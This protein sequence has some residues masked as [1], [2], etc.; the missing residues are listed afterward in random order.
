MTQEMVITLARDAIELTLLLSL[1]FLVVGLV[2]GLIISVFQAATQIQEMSLTFVPKAITMLLAG[3]LLLPFLMN[4][5]L[6]F[7]RHLFA[8]IPKY[9]K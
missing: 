7:T 9:I 5:L 2:V 3:L 8:D 1:P 6:D 4:K